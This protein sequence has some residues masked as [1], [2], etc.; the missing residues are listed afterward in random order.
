ML[1]LGVAFRQRS[2]PSREELIDDWQ[3]LRV[4]LESTEIDFLKAANGKSS[5]SVRAR[6]GLRYIANLSH[7]MVMKLLFARDHKL[8]DKKPDP[9][10]QQA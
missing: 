3:K 6:H 7:E 5:P 10:G 9:D 2:R 4:A 8:D 1:D